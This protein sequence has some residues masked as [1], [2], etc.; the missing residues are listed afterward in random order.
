[1]PRELRSYRAEGIVLRRRNIGD[2]DTIFTVFSER[3]GKFDAVARGVR[4]A[5]SRMRGHLEPLT[6]SRFQIARGRSIDV[7]S[8]AETVRSFPGLIADLDRCAAAIACAELVER[9][10]VDH[11]ENRALYRLF[12]RALD[13]I[14][15]APDYRLVQRFFELHLLDDAGFELQLFGCAVCAA[16]LEEQETLF[17][18]EAGGLVCRE[19]RSGAGAGRLLSVRAIKVLRH[20]ARSSLDAFVELNMGPELHDEVERALGDTIRFHLE[21]E[22]NTSRVI[23]QIGAAGQPGTAGQSSV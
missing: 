17:A 21:R 14:E 15:Q 16:H 19:C 7:F 23:R 5:T 22:L 12:L 8:Q 9:F 20:A 3:E 1:M 11:A 2:A 13:G 18:P 4:K 10:T 6:L